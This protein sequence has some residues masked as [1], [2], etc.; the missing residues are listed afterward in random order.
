MTDSDSERPTFGM[1][2]AA[3]AQPAGPGRLGE[4]PL[5]REVLPGTLTVAAY[6]AEVRPL[7]PSAERAWS[8]AGSR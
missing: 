5:D 1:R 8:C 6:L 2:P 7:I 3:A 4:T